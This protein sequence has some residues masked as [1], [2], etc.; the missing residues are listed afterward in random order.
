MKSRYIFLKRLY[1]DYVIIFY[2][3]NY[4]VYF[5]DIVI[6]RCFKCGSIINTLNS[7]NIN[8]IIVDNL[9]IKVFCFEVNNYLNYFFKS[10]LISIIDE[11]YKYG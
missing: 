6:F 3:N 1:K 4:C 10:Y 5:D 11:I 9:D 2:K 7:L 8:Y